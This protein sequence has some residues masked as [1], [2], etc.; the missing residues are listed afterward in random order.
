MTPAI[1]RPLDRIDG[2]DKVTGRARYAVE[3]PL[4]GILHAALVR[5]VVPRGSIE[6]IDASEALAQ[7]GVALVLTH[8]NRPPLRPLTE[9]EVD[10]SF[11]EMV[12]GEHLMPLDG[13][14]IHYRGQ[15]VAV[16]VAE[17]S[18]QAHHAASLVRVDVVEQ[19]AAIPDTSDPALVLATA[20]PVE[21]LDEEGSAN[22][23]LTHRRGDPTMALGVPGSTVVDALYTTP[24]ESHCTLETPGT[25][26]TWA[27]DTVTVY[28]A[29][30]WTQGYQ[31]GIAK[32]FGL[33]V[34]D[35]RVI[36][37]HVGGAFG[38]K[39]PLWAHSLLAVAA[40]KEC[41]RPVRLPLTRQ[42]MF[43]ATG[44]RPPTFQHVEL[45]AREDGALTAIRH[46]SANVTS[47]K[48]NMVE[49]AARTVSRVL[50]RC[51]NVETS[52]ALVRGD[53]PP[54]SWLR[55]P[56]EAPG[57]FAFETAL[58]EL[59]AAI[60][61]D[62][63]ELRVRNDAE[64]NEAEGRAWSGKHL[65]ECYEI[66]AGRFGWG[67]RDAR[68]G[69]TRD[70]DD[71]VGWGMSSAAYF[72]MKL[73]ASATATIRQDGR[74]VVRLA[75]QDLGTGART[76]FTQVAADAMGLDPS[77]VHVELGDSALPRA[78]I[79][80]GSAGTA[81]NSE[82]LLRVG[83]ALRSRLAEIAVTSPGSSLY[84]LP[85]SEIQHVDGFLTA[86]G[87]PG[88]NESV[89]ALLRLAGAEE[90]TVK[91]DSEPRD[92]IL[93][94]AD[95]HSFGAHFL[96]VR[97]DPAVPRVRVTR[98]VSVMDIGRVVNPKTAASQ[99]SGGVVMGI[100]MALT[101]EGLRDRDGRVLN[102]NLADYAIPVHADVCDIDVS[103]VDEADRNFTETGARGAG[104]IGVI[105]VA[106]AIGN[107][108]YHATGLRFRTIPITP[109]RLISAGLPSV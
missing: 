1:G 76:I 98:V 38:A 68:P 102:D 41:G 70:G 94:A 28:D 93:S 12:V 58:D 72:G 104:E 34:E 103:F 50:Y 54:A 37:D 88:R 57:S 108:V 8:E 26:A 63:V 55:A 79:A 31:R 99:I 67:D 6:S 18:E 7:P 106:A 60:D 44:H 48:S 105:G 91:A 74:A 10:S 45:A 33:P 84:G 95:P 3:H 35:V 107:A 65:R 87:D 46:R 20:L 25:L 56:G 11:M 36:C 64:I 69:T 24:L 78:W 42:Q 59:A 27:G 30:Q 90:V 47:F 53:L 89:A 13:R 71:L 96:E 97:I 15:Y 40:A 5:S 101:E 61:L 17:T 52:H 51:P 100:G 49:A 16:V 83:T 62:P 9:G 21:S 23:M 75:A 4:E 14:E 2:P 73:F 22:T 66:G 43:T 77:A 39:A 86:A 32:A 29:T 19:P 81:T 92:G 80:G 109:Q 82:V 85:P